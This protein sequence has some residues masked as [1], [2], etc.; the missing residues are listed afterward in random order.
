MAPAATVTSTAPLITTCLPS[1]LLVWA[2]LCVGRSV[3]AIYSNELGWFDGEAEDLYPLPYDEA[4]HKTVLLMGG[5]AKV[6][7]VAEEAQASNDHRWAL[8]L[9]KLLRTAAPRDNTSTCGDPPAVSCSQVWA[10]SLAGH[11]S[12][13][14]CLCVLVLPVGVCLS[15]PHSSVVLKTVTALEASSLTSL[16]RSIFNTNGR[17]YLMQSAVERTHP[18]VK[19]GGEH[20]PHLTDAFIDAIPVDLMFDVLAT[21]LRPDL[22]IDSHE[23]I[24]FQVGDAKYYVTVRKGV[25]EVSKGQPLYGMPE[26]VG[27]SV[28]L[29]H[30]GPLA[31]RNTSPD[32]QRA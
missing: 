5:P 17:A 20:A 1:C 28:D 14:C 26:P 24:V 32:K 25:A 4:A 13:G 11:D 3:R 30:P 19:S 22:S 29:Q 15:P 6:L 31:P 8:H 12:V 16:G 7:K 21:R 27:E 2:W 23:A 18:G 10:D 9:L